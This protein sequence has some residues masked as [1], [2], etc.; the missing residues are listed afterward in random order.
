MKIIQKRNYVK[1]IRYIF[2]HHLLNPAKIYR[3]SKKC[4]SVFTRTKGNT[5]TSFLHFM[6]LSNATPRGG[7]ARLRRRAASAGKPKTR[8]AGPAGRGSG[9]RKTG[10]R[11]LRHHDDA[12][13]KPRFFHGRHRTAHHHHHVSWIS[14]VIAAGIFG[15]LPLD[16]FNMNLLVAQATKGYEATVDQSALT[17]DVPKGGKTSVTLTYTN[18]GTLTWNRSGKSFVSLYLVGKTSSPIGGA[19]WRTKDSPAYITDTGVKPGKKTTV[20]FNV[21]GN[22]P[23]TYTET[24]RLAAEDTAWMKTSDMKLTVRV[25]A[26]ASPTT[27]PSS[28]PPSSTSPPATTSS[29]GPSA[30]LLL[31]SA[32]DLTLRGDERIQVTFGFKNTSAAQWN[33]QSLKL[34]GMFPAVSDP[35]GSAHDSTW[36]S[37]S[38]PVRIDTVTKPGEIGFLSFWLKAPARRGTYRVSLALQA[39]GKPVEGGTVDIPIT[40]TAD[41]NII[42]ELP[43]SSPSGVP[44][45]TGPDGIAQSP[46]FY[47]EEPILRVGIF[48][49]TDA[50]MILSANGP[51]RVHQ[52]GNT[53]CSFT[54]GQTV[55]VRFDRANKVYTATG[56]NCQT[57]SADFYHVQRTDDPLAPLTMT[58]F[59]R[60][61]SWLPG[62]NDNTFRSILELRYSPSTDAVWVINELPIEMYLRGL[63]ETSDVSPIEYQ[64]ALLTAARTYAMYHWT[65]A[66]KHAS[67]FFHVDAKYDQVYRGYG[68]EA[69]SP[70]IVQGVTD[71]RGQI[72]TYNQELAITPY[73]SRSDGRTRNWTEVWGGKGFA[74][75]VSVPVPQDNGRVLWGHGVGMSASGALGMANEGSL[76]RDILKH[77]YQGTEVMR[78]Y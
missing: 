63:A 6:S 73:Y 74:W 41:G 14:A 15:L 66:T 18:T 64:K 5:N 13:S 29:G 4:Y 16:L 60:P 19:A 21:Y 20:T 61:V 57:Q 25:G 71:T 58:D 22:T 67:E 54:A 52:K 34:A 40:V 28:T 43:P 9:A 24:L 17:V 35:N 78:F 72:V 32:Q 42:T 1:Y 75:L 45:V 47:T 70:K 44:L 27:P 65:R 33:S 56:P 39:D 59:S 51:F 62:A 50:Q 2:L 26:T 36:I 3:S 49:T 12:L 38:E 37:P 77:F 69:R 46:K 30:L 10:S 76:Y 53:V 48:A 31:R 68:A 8:K 11:V 7:A 55:T 23:G